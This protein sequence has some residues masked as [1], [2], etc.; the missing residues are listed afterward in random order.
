MALNCTMR[1]G[2]RRSEEQCSRPSGSRRC[3]ASALRNRLG[4]ST[5]KIA[6][7]TF[8]TIAPLSSTVANLPTLTPTL[9]VHSP[10]KR[11]PVPL[12]RDFPSFSSHCSQNLS[13]E[14]VLR[15]CCIAAHVSHV[16]CRRALRSHRSRVI[17]PLVDAS[18][19]P[20]R[21]LE[22][23]GER[24][25]THY[26]ERQGRLFPIL[27]NISQPMYLP[28]LMPF[29]RQ[30]RRKAARLNPCARQVI[31]Q[32]VSMEP[33]PSTEVRTALASSTG[34][35]PSSLLGYALRW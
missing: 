20:L 24:C 4:R 14:N 2:A 7:F 34:I 32:A 11:S 26:N 31:S 19:F 8:D 25:S 6:L 16:R 29:S 23:E 17:T 28:L 1:S 30:K 3:S 21:P 10:G 35:I 15:P 33:N 27:E 9:G 22:A 5:G 12:L 18:P 13:F